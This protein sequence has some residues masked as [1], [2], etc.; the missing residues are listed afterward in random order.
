MPGTKLFYFSATGNTLATA[1]QL[2][3]RLPDT[4]LERIDASGDAHAVHTDA[5]KVGI[6]FPVY[7]LDP[8]PPVLEFARRLR[9]DRCDYAFAVATHNGD[10]GSALT[11]LDR[12]LARNGGALSA[13]WSL[14]MPGTSLHVVDYTNPPEERRARLDQARHR[15]PEI[16]AAVEKGERHA[17]EQRARFGERCKSR[18]NRTILTSVYPAQRHFQVEESCSGCATCAR[19]CPCGNVRLEA[20]RPSWGD[21]CV[22]CLACLHWCPRSAVQ[23]GGHT[24][25]KLR[26]HHPDIQV[27]DVALR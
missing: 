14:L 1:R 6:L 5:T 3:A 8:A 20:G 16:A 13:G 25:G 10:P 19:V 18:V 11:V 24:Q 2:A 27:S 23:I 15:I 22:Q 12:A 9:L 26:Y 7:C 21:D 17:L 4:T